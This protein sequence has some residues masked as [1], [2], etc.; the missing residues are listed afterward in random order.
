LQ[1]RTLLVHESA[2]TLMLHYRR[3]SRA[4]STVL[5]RHLTCAKHWL[6]SSEACG[7]GVAA[8]S[9]FRVNEP[10]EHGSGDVE[11]GEHAADEHEPGDAGPDEH[12]PDEH[13]SR[14][15]PSDDEPPER[16]RARNNASSL[17][18]FRARCLCTLSRRS[19]WAGARARCGRQPSLSCDYATRTEPN[20]DLRCAPGQFRSLVHERSC[21]RMQRA[22]RPAPRPACPTRAGAGPAC[23]RRGDNTCPT[24]ASPATRR[25]KPA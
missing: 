6:V 11:P 16:E 24:H 7:C 9:L 15:D 23:A 4:P 3:G 25:G 2:N 13:E 20:C 19:G 17:L 8:V 22:R 21:C 1:I 5:R 10:D 18:S 12:G 14:A